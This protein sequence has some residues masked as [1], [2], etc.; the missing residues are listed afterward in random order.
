MVRW[1]TSHEVLFFVCA[2]LTNGKTQNYQAHSCSVRHSLCFVFTSQSPCSTYTTRSG[3]WSWLWPVDFMFGPTQQTRSQVWLQFCLSSTP[4]PP[5]NKTSTPNP[6][7][8]KPQTPN[9]PTN[10][11]STPNP[12]TNKSSTPN[13][14]TNKPS[15]PNP[16]TNK[17]QTPNSP[18]NKPST[19]NPSTNKPQTPN[20]ITSKPQTPNL[21]TNKPSTPNPTTNKPSTPNPPTSKHNCI[22]AGNR[23]SKMLRCCTSHEMLFFKS[24]ALTN[25]KTQNYQTH[26]CSTRHSS[27]FHLLLKHPVAPTPLH[28]VSPL[29]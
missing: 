28:S 4:N 13:P 24:A 8:N 6:T 21:P 27:C 14:P 3:C 11:P 25:G 26:S 23:K 2:A 29:H 5:T 18:T 1:C 15:T 16:T 17:P 19:P 12:P 7:T 22:H 10:K 9:P 20:P